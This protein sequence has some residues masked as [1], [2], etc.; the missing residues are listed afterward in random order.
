MCGVS[1]RIAN[2]TWGAE[3]VGGTRALPAG[4]NLSLDYYLG[5][6]W[7]YTRSENINSPLNGE[8]TGPRPGPANT[9]ILQMKNSGQGRVN[10]VFAG[11]RTTS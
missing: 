9:N 10:A 4:F 8:P 5:R 2:L 1:A 11:W 7:N 3:N 6:I